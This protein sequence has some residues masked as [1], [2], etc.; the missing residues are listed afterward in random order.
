MKMTLG[1]Q[2]VR[3]GDYVVVSSMGFPQ[4]IDVVTNIAQ[5]EIKTKNNR[6]FN[7]LTGKAVGPSVIYEASISVEERDFKILKLRLLLESVE[8]KLC[9]IKTSI[10]KDDVSDS[11]RDDLLK[12]FTESLANLINLQENIKASIDSK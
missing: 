12:H 6:F 7:R 5:H 11:Y 1:L 2:D 10:Y 3:I 9:S 8:S 4:C